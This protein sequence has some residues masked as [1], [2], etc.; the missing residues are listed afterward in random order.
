MV[1]CNGDGGFFFLGRLW[2]LWAMIINYVFILFE[3]ERMGR[4]SYQC[5]LRSHL[6]LNMPIYLGLGS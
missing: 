6:W 4:E 2:T 1:L 3:R 5:H